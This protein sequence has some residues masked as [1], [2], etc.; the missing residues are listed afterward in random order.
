MLLGQVDESIFTNVF[1][2]GLRKLQ[3]LSTLDDTAA[4][5]EFVQIIQRFGSRPL[6]D[7]IRQLRTART[8][9]VN[10]SE[11]GQIPQLM[12]RREKLKDEIEEHASRGRRW[13]ELA[14]QRRS[15]AV[16]ISELQERVAQWEHE[17]R[18]D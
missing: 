17:G 1:A 16:E 3:E 8:H 11:A 9:L 13:T 15:Q 5:D 10:S 2:I 4:A 14:A 6:V 12:L 18:S 7:V